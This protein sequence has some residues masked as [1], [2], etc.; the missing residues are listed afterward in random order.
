MGQDVTWWLMPTH[1]ELKINYME[2]VWPKKVIKKMYKTEEFDT[3]QDDSDPDKKA[4]AAEQ[5]R[6][7]AEKRLMCIFMVVAV[8]GWFF[9][10]QDY[11]CNHFYN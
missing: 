11:I 8:L 6:A 1:P 10:G 3:E 2:R 9:A 7:K 5:R 4:F